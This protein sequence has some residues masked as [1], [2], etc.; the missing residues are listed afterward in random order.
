MRIVSKFE[1]LVHPDYVAMYDKGAELGLHPLQDR[2]R[3]AWD[4]RVNEIV[5][6]DS[7]LIYVTVLDRRKLS[8]GLKDAGKLHNPVERY[9]IAR[10]NRYREILDGNFILVPNRIAVAPYLREEMAKR[11]IL[12]GEEPELKVYGEFYGAGFTCVESW[13]RQGKLALGVKD[14]KYTILEE[15]TFRTEDYSAVLYWQ[16]DRNANASNRLE[17]GD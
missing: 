7:A 17:I 12:L 14:D 11:E 3:T 2:L 9:D 16:R 6:N 1:M 13:G 15:L 5:K 10:I 8:R 4:D